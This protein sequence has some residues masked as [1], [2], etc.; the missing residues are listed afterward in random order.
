MKNLLIIED[1]DLVLEVLIADV[2]LSYSQSKDGNI[3]VTDSII[4]AFQMM[5]IVKFSGVITDLD[6][7]DGN[8]IELAQGHPEVPFLGITG[9]GAIWL[10]GNMVDIL[11]KPFYHKGLRKFLRRMK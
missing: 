3:F 11:P 7:P 8:G 2:S 6:L 1:D 9:Y 10:P 5:R 4:E